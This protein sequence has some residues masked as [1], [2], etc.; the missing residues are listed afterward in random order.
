[1]QNLP[2][3]SIIMTPRDRRRQLDV[4]LE[5]IFAQNYPNLEIVIVEDR[6]SEGSLGAFCA[7]NNIKYDARRTSLEG[8]MNPAPLLNRGIKMAVNDIIIFQNAECRHDTPTLIADL[9]T[10]IIK[11]RAE[12]EPRLSTCACVRDTAENG[13][14]GG[15]L[16]HPREGHR[17]GWVSYFCQAVG[18][19]SVLKI[20]GFEEEFKQYGFEDDMFE[21]MLRY[22][23]VQI[24]Y[25]EQALASHLWHPRFQGDQ[26]NSSP[27]I[28]KRIRHEIEVGERPPVAN[29]NRPWG[30]I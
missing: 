23:G 7:R 30:N 29:Y 21:F 24:K 1:M 12:Q 19:E 8:W 14:I 25:V 11:A 16:T 22:S 28:Y 18:R 3:V 6:P 27:E 9:V 26:N 20:Q 15:W 4:T 17:A 5:T 2:S 13:E 10:P